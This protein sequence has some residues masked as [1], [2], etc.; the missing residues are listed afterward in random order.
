MSHFRFGVD[1]GPLQIADRLRLSEI[2]KAEMEDAEMEKVEMEKAEI[3]DAVFV[4]KVK[5]K[6]ETTTAEWMIHL[7]I[8]RGLLL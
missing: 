6:I 7:M 1:E 8:L 5:G 2:E 4:K 3:E